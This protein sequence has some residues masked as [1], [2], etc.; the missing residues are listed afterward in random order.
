MARFPRDV[1]GWV[2]LLRKRW[3]RGAGRAEVIRGLSVLVNTYLRAD[4]A[5]RAKLRARVNEPLGDDLM[6]FAHRAAEKAVRRKDRAFLIRGQAALAAGD[7]WIDPRDILRTFSLIDHSA[8]KLRM[9][10][11]RLFESSRDLGGKPFAELV[12]DWLDREDYERSID[13][14]GFKNAE[15]GRFRYVEDDDDLW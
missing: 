9:N 13:G 7:E 1:P 8:G 2:T 11:R 15:S 14:M 3:P 5:G 12:D 6:A 10:Y 4:A